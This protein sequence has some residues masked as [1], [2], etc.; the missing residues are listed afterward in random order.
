[1]TA[2]RLQELQKGLE[3]ISVNFNQ[4]VLDLIKDIEKE[5]I[6]MNVDDQL[7][8]GVNSK[9]QKITPP[10]TPAYRK[11]KERRGLVA[12]RVTTRLEGDYHDSF[13]ITYHDDSFDLDAKDLKKRYLERMY[14]IDLYG[15]TDANKKKLGNMLLPRLIEVINQ[16]LNLA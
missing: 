15:L 6:K 11:R 3:F 8:Q 9:G 7:F 5:V 13:F 4:I 1:M 14:S 2:E 16:R 10:Y 12:D